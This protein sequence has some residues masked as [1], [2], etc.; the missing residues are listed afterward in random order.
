LLTLCSLWLRLVAL[1]PLD[2]AV[3]RAGE[4]VVADS[5]CGAA[6]GVSQLRFAQRVPEEPNADGVMLDERLGLGPPKLPPLSLPLLLQSEL[7]HE[8]PLS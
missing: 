5:E 6:I 1:Q 3:D 4:V 2:V 8:E 7:P